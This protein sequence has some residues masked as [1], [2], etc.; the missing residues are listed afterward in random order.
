MNISKN[1]ENKSSGLIK[2][3]L[4]AGGRDLIA[5][6][7]DLAIHELIPVEAIEHIPILGQLIKLLSISQS[8]SD[9]ILLR[10]IIAFLQDLNF[11]DEEK[12]KFVRE[13]EDEK[14]A[15]KIG[16]LLILH[17]DKF[18][19]LEKPAILAKILKAK[20]RKKIDIDYENFRR[21]SMSID[22]AFIDDLNDLIN[23][24]RHNNE[25][26]ERLLSSGLSKIQSTAQIYEPSASGN[27]IIN[28]APPPPVKISAPPPSYPPRSLSPIKKDETA[29]IQYELS[30]LGELFIKI[31]RSR[32]E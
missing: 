23:Q 7:G 5:Q 25:L 18:N 29:R 2:T 30:E 28:P 3:I 21:L 12:N 26:L 14:Y 19:D 4:E 24:S 27:R 32:L 8:V 13:L 15:K 20:L 10:K 22:V 6:Y 11:T 9:R 16:E 1:S 31:M 17:L